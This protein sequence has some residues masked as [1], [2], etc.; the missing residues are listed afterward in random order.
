[1]QQQIILRLQIV[2]FPVC[3]T[4]SCRMQ[5]MTSHLLLNYEW[6]SSVLTTE[7][8]PLSR[9]SL[10]P[11]CCF[12]SSHFSIHPASLL[13]LPASASSLHPHVRMGRPRFWFHPCVGSR[14]LSLCPTGSSIHCL[15]WSKYENYH[16]G[17]DTGGGELLAVAAMRM[18][19]MWMSEAND[20]EDLPMLHMCICVRPGL[21][22]GG[23]VRWELPPIVYQ[24]NHKYHFSLS[25]SRKKQ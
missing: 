18:M 13:L 9:S 19:W 14:C 23:P 22:F 3:P 16:K 20:E 6:N 12:Q 10:H 7:H 8:L 5:N 17:Q 25:L 15:Q 11:R 2:S 21:W 4:G 24:Y 1:M